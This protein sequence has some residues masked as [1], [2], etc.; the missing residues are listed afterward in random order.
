[1]DGQLD[2]FELMYPKKDNTLNEIAEWFSDEFNLL[3][4]LWKNTFRVDEVKLEKWEHVHQKKETLEIYLK[5]YKEVSAKDGY[6]YALTQFGDQENAK[7]LLRELSQDMF[8]QKCY[9]DKDFSISVSPWFIAIYWKNFKDKEFVM[10]EN[11]RAL[12]H[13]CEQCKNHEICQG[14]GCT[15]RHKLQELIEKEQKK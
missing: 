14:T 13:L 12:Q 7:Q 11:L 6:K 15:P 5:T 3:N 4:T 9:E 2:L 1:M 10:D 8:I